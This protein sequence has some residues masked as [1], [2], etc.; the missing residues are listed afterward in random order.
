MKHRSTILRYASLLVLLAGSPV[1]DNA[2]AATN[3]VSEAQQEQTRLVRGIVTDQAGDPIVGATVVIKGTTKAVLTQLDGNFDIKV[4]D[5]H[6][7]LLI[8]YVGMEQVELP[9][10]KSQSDYKVVMQPS[11]QSIDDVVVV[12]YGKQK[13]ATVTG[14][15]AQVEGK[16]LE[17]AH[18]ANLSNTLVGRMPGVIANNRSGQPGEDFSSI[19]IRGKGSFGNNSPL[20]VIDGVANRPGGID[21]LNPSDI[22]SVSVL[23]DASAAIYGAQ[24]ANGVILVTT[25]RGKESKPTISYD[26]SFT[27]QQPTRSPDWLNAYQYMNYQD[28]VSRYFG[29]NE[30]YKDIKG[31]YLD[32][33]IDRKRYADTDWNKAVMRELTP[34]TQH[35]LALRGGTENVSYYTSIGYL[36]QEYA[37]RNSDRNFNTLQARTNVDAKV[38]N[39]IRVSVDMGFRQENRNAP[40][41]SSGNI[42]WETMHAYPFLFDY[43]ENGLTGAGVEAGRN[44]VLLGTSIPGYHKVT[45]NFLNSKVTLDIQMPWITKGLSVSAYAA[46][47]L[48][49]RAEKKM[50]DQWDAYEY[51]P[52]NDKYNNIRERTGDKKIW[53]Q[54]RQDNNQTLTINARLAYDRTFGD[55]AVSAFVAYE[56]SRFDGAWF[57]AYRENFL[58]SNLDYMFAGGDKNKT[59]DGK[60]SVSA[61]QNIFGRVNYGYQNKYLLEA[62]L[63][64]D[65]SQ[66]FANDVRWGLF[67]GV[68]AGW[69]L[70][71]EN[72]MKNAKSV[73]ELKLRASWGKLGNDRV[74]PFQYLSTFTLGDGGVFGEDPTM[75]QGFYPGRMANPNITWEIVETTNVGVDASFW[76]GM[77]SFS[78]QYF[79]S[80]RTNILTPKLASIPD[81]TGIVLPDQNIGEIQNQGIELEV[82]HRNQIG[83]WSYYV[84]GNFSFI[85][86]KI[87]YFDEAANIPQWQRRT[88]GPIDSWLAYKTDGIYQNWDQIKADGKNVLPGTKPGDIR[89]LD[90]DGVDGITS[91]DRVRMN[92]TPTPAIVFGLSLGFEWKGL[93]L[94]MLFQGQGNAQQMVRPYSYNFDQSIYEGRWISEAETPNARYPRATNYRDDAINTKDSDFWLIDAS[95]LRLKNLELSYAMPRDL[96]KKA[97]IEQ[98]RFFLS[99]TNLFVI[100][101]IK[102]QDPETGGDFTKDISA[103]NSNPGANGMYYPQQRTFSFGVNITF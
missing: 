82:M 48:Q 93:G 79:Y 11:V 54:Q 45:D 52:L 17:Q 78:A 22:E 71:Q 92:N 61:R 103:A 96:L 4:S 63:R 60:G 102:I 64:Y 80:L 15:V 36:Y 49:F 65:G 6:E 26:G 5:S 56:Q 99:G 3:S 27:L 18:S 91:G 46:Y 101:K 25:K 69:R 38:S 10:L 12:G 23:K 28:E 41:Y 35:S 13:K 7:M 30:E 76:K 87:L 67:P 8:S 100:D 86:N 89:Y 32:G 98:V 53:L 70:S 42:F 51:D 75:N 50:M 84:G 95:F 31:G 57:N 16:A 47:D 44:P 20:F 39:D 90:V 29:R 58:S 94:N 74:D 73:D 81:Y 55:H 72:F 83:D 37:Y 33:T 62:T 77:L 59:N 68:S 85:E 43:Y 2:T 97:K 34:Q 19:L 21:R 66:N 24:A 1:I 14:S 9:L 88:G 40:I